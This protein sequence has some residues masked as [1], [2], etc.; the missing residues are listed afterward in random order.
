MVAGLASREYEGRCRELGLETLET[1]RK[2]QDLMQTY[3]LVQ[4]IEKINRVQL[5]RHVNRGRTRQDADPLDKKQEK[6]RLEI[7][8]NFY[9]QRIVKDWKELPKKVKNAR[10]IAGFNAAYKIFKDGGLGGIP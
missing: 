5:L 9:T 1:R 4:G 10:P 6:F 3:K 2:Q 7:R 8:K